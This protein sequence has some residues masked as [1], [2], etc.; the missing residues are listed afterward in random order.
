MTQNNGHYAVQVH[1]ISRSPLSVPNCQSKARMRVN[2]INL[3]PLPRYCGVL[4]KFSPSTG[5]PLLKT[6]NSGLRNLASRNYRGR[7][8]VRCKAYFDI[9]NRLGVND[10]YD[11]RTDILT[12]NAVLC[13]AA[14]ND[15][16][17]AVHAVA[18]KLSSRQC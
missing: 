13:C 6:L 15:I 14:K 10:E 11:R 2:N 16:V 7:S 12:A 18:R 3:H 4:I 1:S 9:L 17:D 8:I 5:V